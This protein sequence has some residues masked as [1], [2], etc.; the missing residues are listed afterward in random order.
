[1]VTSPTSKNR[2]DERIEIERLMRD[3]QRAERADRCN[4]DREPRDERRAVTL[5][6]RD[7]H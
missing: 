3:P 4:R 7:N 5:V 1:L 2:S 6:Q